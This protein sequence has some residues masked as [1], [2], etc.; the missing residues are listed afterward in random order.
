MFVTLLA[1]EAETFANSVS[2]ANPVP[3]LSNLVAIDAETAPNDPDIWDAIWA[4][5]DSKVGL[6]RTLVYSTLEAATLVKPLPFPKKDPLKDPVSAALIP[7]GLSILMFFFFYSLFATLLINIYF[8]TTTVPLN[9]L[10]NSI[11]TALADVDLTFAGIT[12]SF[13]VSYT[14]TTGKSSFK[15]CVIV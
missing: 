15:L 3:R 7:I 2:V 6:L 9:E 10:I 4:D 11:K 1:N 13:T 12:C 5:P 8:F 14:C